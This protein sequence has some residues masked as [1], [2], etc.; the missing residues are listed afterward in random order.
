MRGVTLQVLALI[1]G[2]LVMPASAT[3]AAD[4]AERPQFAQSV[5][6]AQQQALDQIYAEAA[7]AAQ[8]KSEAERKELFRATMPRVIEVLQPGARSSAYAKLF[9][10]SAALRTARA[11]LGIRMG[12]GGD[13]DFYP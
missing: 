2:L 10:E 13:I 9:A 11:D 6:A 8:G 12:F 3:R 1:C 7:A 5:T 4:L